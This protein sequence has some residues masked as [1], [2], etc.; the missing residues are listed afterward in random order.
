[1]ALML[2]LVVSD[3]FCGLWHV[4]FGKGVGK[5]ERPALDWIL[6]MGSQLKATSKDVDFAHLEPKNIKESC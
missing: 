5:L 2:F 1:M 4:P 6:I 3:V